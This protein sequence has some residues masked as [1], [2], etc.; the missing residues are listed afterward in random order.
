MRASDILDMLAE[1][2]TPTEIR[3][4]FPYI[5]DDDVRA[6]L[7]WAARAVSNT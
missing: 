7:Y 5:A 1:G 6:A 3:E 2:A 4:D